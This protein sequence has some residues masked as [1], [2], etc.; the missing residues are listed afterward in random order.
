MF[1]IKTITPT[2]LKARLDAG[3]A[4][5]VVI[6][7]RTETELEVASLDFAQHIEMN[8][9]PGSMGDL[10]EDKTLVFICRSGNRSMQVC[11]FLA[12]NGWDADKLYNL[13]DGILGWAR[14]VDPSLPTFY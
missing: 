2:E 7:V 3:E 4:D 14:D 10:P 13:Q 5:L 11:M 8:E 1:P 12:A 9:I 6:D